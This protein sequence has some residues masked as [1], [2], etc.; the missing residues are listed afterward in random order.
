MHLYDEKDKFAKYRDSYVVFHISFFIIIAV[1]IIGI[2]VILIYSI[3]FSLSVF[4]INI[5]RHLN[6]KVH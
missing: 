3:H 4:P 1:I 5:H 2:V 6:Y